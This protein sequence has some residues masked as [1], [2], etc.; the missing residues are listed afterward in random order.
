MS[1]TTVKP[2]T[3]IPDYYSA[4]EMTT[5][6]LAFD[7]AKCKKCDICTFICPARSISR[8]KGEG[9]WN[10]G[11]PYLKSTTPGMTDCVACGCCVAACPVAAISITGGFAPG[12]FFKRLTQTTELMPPNCYL[13]SK[14]SDTPRGTTS[15][16]PASSP[17]APP[18]SRRRA[19]RLSVNRVKWIGR[20]LRAAAMFGVHEIQKGRGW[21]TFRKFAFGAPFDISWAQLLEESSGQVPHKDCV[22]YNDEVYTYRQMDENANRVANYLLE[23]GGACG[24]GIGLMLR[25]SPRFLD[26]FFGAQKLGMYVVPINPELKGDGLAYIINHSDISTLVVDAELIGPVQECLGLLER[27]DVND[28]MVNDREPEAQDIPLPAGVSLL[29]PAYDHAPS[30]PRT[31]CNPEDICLIIY[32]S[33]TTGL[34][35]GVVY[36][37]NTSGVQLLALGGKAFFNAKDTYYT[38]LSLC[39]G[40][41]L[42]LTVT[43]SLAVKC[44]IALSRKFSASRFWDTVRQYNA[45]VFNTIG[46]IIPILMKQPPGPDDR[47]HRVRMVFSAACPIEM[48]EPFEK[49]F[50]VELYEGYGAVD[51]GG[52]KLMNLGTA[53]PGSL[54]RPSKRGT[55]RIVD[56]YNREVPDHTPGE[57][58]FKTGKKRSLVEYYKN[59]EATGQKS[60]DGW[61]HT[62]DT[63]KRDAKGYL[64]FVGRNSESMRKGGENVSAYEVEHVIMQY[65]AVEDVAVYAVPS[66]LGED[67]IMASVKP[68][69]HKQIDPDELRRFLIGK[70]AKYAI[71]RYIRIVTAFPKTSTH[72]VIKEAL[73]GEGVTADTYDA[74]MCSKE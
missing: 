4:A 50:G 24:R 60:A 45:T 35:K 8:D 58:L 18:I 57:L 42:F 22:L 21:R 31:H 67:E 48:W 5:G 20:M 15:S 28:I 7:R 3:R 52:K 29:G 19:L 56:E 59:S 38:Y 6:T 30:R 72:R 10:D 40:N 1:L 13:P 23:R 46:T 66:D 62:G 39:H 12:H 44:T 16:R 11:F 36:R 43:M 70:L 14:D 27:I 33:G 26:L 37:Y 55:I 17:P 53:P 74:V 68:V 49:R 41:A 64:Y 34:P 71:P 47:R 73:A 25:N 54:G 9:A 51:G 65:P 61:L 63:V 69:A 2:W 32:T